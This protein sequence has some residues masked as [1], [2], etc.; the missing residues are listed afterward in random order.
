[1]VQV[2]EVDKLFIFKVLLSSSYYGYG[3]NTLQTDVQELDKLIEK[4]IAQYQ[5]RHIILCGHS[6]GKC[7]DNCKQVSSRVMRGRVSR[8]GDVFEAW[9]ICRQNQCG[10][11]ARTSIGQG[12]HGNVKGN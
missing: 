4:L 1:M 6:T 9:K 8:F 11:F 5:A 3:V 7:F 12:I 2:R 10:H